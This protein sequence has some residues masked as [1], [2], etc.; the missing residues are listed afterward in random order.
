M[1]ALNWLK[2]LTTTILQ[3][4][5]NEMILDIRLLTVANSLATSI[6]EEGIL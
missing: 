6:V 1:A 5:N 2:L 3:F 4:Q